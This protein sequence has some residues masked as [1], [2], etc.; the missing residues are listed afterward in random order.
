MNITKQKQTHRFREQISGHQWGEE[1]GRSNTR[2]RLRGA[3]YYDTRI[4]H[5]LQETQSILIITLEYNL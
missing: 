5:T 3:N 2:R 1:G 4:Y